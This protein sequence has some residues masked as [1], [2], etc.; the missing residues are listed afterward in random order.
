[1]VLSA[2]AVLVQVQQWCQPCDSA[3]QVR[4]ALEHAFFALL[5][6]T[7][8]PSAMQASPVRSGVFTKPLAPY[9]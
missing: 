6:G 1:M 5:F 8:P 4:K 7:P 3:L 2:R 9:Y